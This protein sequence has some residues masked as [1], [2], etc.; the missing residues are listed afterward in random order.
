MDVQSDIKDSLAVFTGVCFSLL[1]NGSSS[2]PVNKWIG[3]AHTGQPTLIGKQTPAK[4]CI[5]HKV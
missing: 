1:F 4:S 3:P 5:S 2:E